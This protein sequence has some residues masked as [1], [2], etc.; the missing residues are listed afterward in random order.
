MSVFRLIF[1]P[2]VTA[3]LLEQ[4]IL[5]L[6]RMHPLARFSQREK[7]LNTLERAQN[8]SRYVRQLG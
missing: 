8:R 2:I 5:I 4:N 6:L 7:R 3:Q 1:T